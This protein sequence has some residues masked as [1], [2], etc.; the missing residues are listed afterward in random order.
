MY[1]AFQS[2]G[3][4][5]RKHQRPDTAKNDKKVW[6]SGGVLCWCTCEASNGWPWCEPCDRDSGRTRSPFQATLL[7]QGRAT[8]RLACSPCSTSRFSGQAR[9]QLRVGIAT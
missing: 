7:A 4:T 2:G 5:R 9:K 1:T 8:A 6:Q 3:I